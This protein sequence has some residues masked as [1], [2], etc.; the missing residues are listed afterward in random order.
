MVAVPMPWP[1]WV[2]AATRSGDGWDGMACGRELARS[3][4]TCGNSPLASATVPVALHDPCCHG[5]APLLLCTPQVLGGNGTL[6]Q[7]VVITR[8]VT[9]LGPAFTRT[10]V[11]EVSP[12]Y[13]IVNHLSEY[14]QVQQS[15]A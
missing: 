7:F 1:A 15:G 2:L 8:P 13:V 3:R 6:F 4:V 5:V 9:A 14:V 12:R 10:R 11:L